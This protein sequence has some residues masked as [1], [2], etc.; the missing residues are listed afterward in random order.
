[1]N[2]VELTLSQW[3]WVGVVH[4]LIHGKSCRGGLRVTVS[5]FLLSFLLLII[6][7]LVFHPPSASSSIEGE[8]VPAEGDQLSY[9]VC[10]I[11]P[12][13]EKVQA[14]EVSITQL[15]PGIKH[16]TWSGTVVSSW[17]STATRSWKR[18]KRWKADWVVEGG[19]AIAYN[20]KAE[21]GRGTQLFFFL[22]AMLALSGA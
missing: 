11:P 15:K 10:S 13:Y 19:R 20:H 6:L 9:K 8:Y 16:E 17:S 21:E 2:D 14:V 18:K 4:N 1:M 5:M 22:I 7:S 3:I 12:K